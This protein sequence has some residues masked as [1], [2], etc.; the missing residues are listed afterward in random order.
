LIPGGCCVIANTYKRPVIT[1]SCNVTSWCTTA[2][3]LSVPK[4]EDHPIILGVIEGTHC[5]SLNLNLEPTLP[6]PHIHPEWYNISSKKAQPWKSYF[7]RNIQV[8]KAWRKECNSITGPNCEKV[9]ISDDE[10][11]N[12]S[13]SHDEDSNEESIN[14]DTS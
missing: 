13:S 12:D 3:F 1:Y 4:Q 7:V 10:S 9:D 14:E 6:I 8:Y 11:S 2:P 5:I